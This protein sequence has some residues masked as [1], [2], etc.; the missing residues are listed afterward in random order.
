MDTGSSTG[1]RPGVAIL[2]E[3][4]IQQ[5]NTIM[6]HLYTQL[7]NLIP[8]EKFSELQHHLY[9]LGLSVARVDIQQ[10]LLAKMCDIAGTHLVLKLLIQIKASKSDTVVTLSVLIPNTRKFVLKRVI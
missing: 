6:W 3:R 2:H 5:R 1:L 8:S 10:S 4:K 9:D 7:R